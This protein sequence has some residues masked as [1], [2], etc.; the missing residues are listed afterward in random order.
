MYVRR[1]WLHVVK[2]Q[3]TC[4]QTHITFT[5]T[6]G[7][8]KEIAAERERHIRRFVM[9]VHSAEWNVKTIIVK[10]VLVFIYLLV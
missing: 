2:A 7:R 5:S 1:I 4:K 8:S 6:R 9:L 3:T 10:C